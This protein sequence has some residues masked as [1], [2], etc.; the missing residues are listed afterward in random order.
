MRFF[1]L[2]K[3][4]IYR[5]SGVTFLETVVALAVLGTIAVI[6]LGGLVT[7]SKAAF[8]ADERATAESLGQSQM[9]WTQSADY[10]YGATQYPPAA[11]PGDKDYINYSA[12]ITTQPLHEPDD[13]IQK[14]TV[15]V[16][17]SGEQVLTLEGYKT[18]R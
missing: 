12:N 9:E 2:F 16:K 15:I 7:T 4:F 13:G 11:I 18:D 6:F 10:I 1:S 3:V 14:I 8:T 17:R 5:E